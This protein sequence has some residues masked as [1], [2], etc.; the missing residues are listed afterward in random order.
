MYLLFSVIYIYNT[1]Q[2]HSLLNNT[3]SIFY[4][5]SYSILFQY[6]NVT[7]VINTE[8][9]PRIN[10][11]SQGEPQG[12]PRGPWSGQGRPREA[13]GGQGGPKGGPGGAKGAPWGAQEVPG[14]AQGRPT[15]GA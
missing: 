1:E 6:S 9:G 10:P 8:Q 14:E 2:I 4:I 11:G 13:K 12:D 3:M 15:G 7:G 5:Y